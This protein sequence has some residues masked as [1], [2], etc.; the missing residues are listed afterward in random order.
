MTTIEQIAEQLVNGA[1]LPS[2]GKYDDSHLAGALLSARMK[3]FSREIN[4]EWPKRW[5][6][7]VENMEAELDRLRN[8]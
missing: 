5:I 3:A 4:R 7:E 2:A 6:E 8:G 1:T